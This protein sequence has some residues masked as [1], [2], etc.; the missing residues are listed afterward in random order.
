VIVARVDGE[1]IGRLQVDARLRGLYAGPGGSRLPGPDTAEGRQLRRWVIQVLAVV[2][3]LEHEA[4]RRGLAAAGPM[5]AVD[6]VELGGIVAA[7]LAQSPHA[8]AVFDAVT[9]GVTV[10][11]AE[12]RAA[13]AANPDLAGEP[14]RLVRH[15]RA[16]RPVNGGRPY[17]MRRDDPSGHL[18]FAAAPGDVVRDG[19]DTLEVLGV[20]AGAGR[21]VAAMLLDAARGRAFTR[22]L[23]VQLR[24][25]VVLSPGSEHPADPAQPDHTHRH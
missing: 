15:V 9:G 11:D 3:V 19:P 20:A 1:P 12:V 6:R 4:G 23:D 13:R 16:A 10:T 21:D 8:R 14:L 22:W 5:P 24:D 25:R 2:A 7:A 17:G 18:V